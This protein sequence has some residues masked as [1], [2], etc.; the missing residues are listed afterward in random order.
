MVHSGCKGDD[1]GGPLWLAAHLITAL[2]TLAGLVWTALDLMAL[3]HDQAAR[4]ARLTGFAAL[5]GALLGVQLV[6][7][8]LMAG[9]R[10]GHVTDQWPLMNGT[11]WPGPTQIG[12]TLGH[13]VTADAAIVHFIHRWFAWVVVA[14]LV[15]MARR[16]KRRGRGASIAIHSALA[17]DPAGHRHGDERRFHSL[18]VMHQGWAP[19]WWWQRGGAHILGHAPDRAARA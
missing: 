16:V 9:L 13:A 6:W 18:A 3:A 14:A 7:G 11:V 1:G 15:V 12:Q 17:P 8:A 10:A 4:P 5:C 19:C 2:F